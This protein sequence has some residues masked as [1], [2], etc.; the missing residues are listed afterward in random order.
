MQ[1]ALDKVNARLAALRSDEDRQRSNVT[2]LNGAD[3][4][5]RERFVHDLNTTED[6]IAAA[7]KDLTAAQ[8]ALQTAKDDLAAKIEFLQLNETL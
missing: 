3:K 4:A 2:A 6:Q 5:A 1:T 8:A 7:Q